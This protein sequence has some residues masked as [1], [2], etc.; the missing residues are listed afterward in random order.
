MDPK[1]WGGW[2][3]DRPKQP[4]K[5]A[6]DGFRS[7]AGAA[8]DLMRDLE[9]Q[10]IQQTRGYGDVSVRSILKVFRDCADLFDEAAKP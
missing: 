2:V 4:Q 7:A 10:L 8:A 1:S 5:T 3:K 9:R 6:T